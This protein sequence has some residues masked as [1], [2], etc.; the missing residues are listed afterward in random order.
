MQ[1]NFVSS[2]QQSP[3]PTDYW[4]R[5]ISPMNREWWLIGG[6]DPSSEVGGGTGTPGFPDNTNIYTNNYNFVPYAQGPKSAHIAWRR[7]GALDGIFGGLIDGAYTQY[8][9]P[10]LMYNN[11]VSTFQQVGPGQ[12]GNPNLVFEGRM[13]PS[14]NKT[15]QRHHTNSMGM[16]LISKLDKSTGTSQM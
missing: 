4:T 15:I 14:H 7:Q 5:P 16:L 11:A 3:L 10:N 2:W 8:Q 6:N 9:A 1:E 13:L 12:S